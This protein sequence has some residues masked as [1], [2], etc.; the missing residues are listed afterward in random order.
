MPESRL[1]K[2]RDAYRGYGVLKIQRCSV[3][4]PICDEYVS[5]MI[6]AEAKKSDADFQEAIEMAEPGYG[7]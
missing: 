6:R 4:C 2:T 1:R 5:P 7:I 3:P